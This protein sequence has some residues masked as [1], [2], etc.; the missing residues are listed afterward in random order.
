MT[1]ENMNWYGR[2]PV[3]MGLQRRREAWMNPATSQFYLALDRPAPMNECPGPVMAKERR[4]DM[5]GTGS[6]HHDDVGQ[7]GRDECIHPSG[8][9]HDRCG[10]VSHR[11]SQGPW[12]RKMENC[13]ERTWLPSLGP[14]TWAKN[15]YSKTLHL[16]LL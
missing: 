12:Y 5:Q 8:R 11:H 4:E 14:A 16:L 3:E 6:T 13:Q 1:G 15:L 10:H 2:D 7:M 9:A